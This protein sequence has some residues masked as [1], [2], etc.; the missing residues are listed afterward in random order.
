MPDGSCYC[1]EGRDNVHTEGGKDG[2]KF[3]L[4]LQN[5][6]ELGILKKEILFCKVKKIT[7]CHSILEAL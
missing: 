4:R 5:E 7:R 2:P 3:P 6:N 1:N